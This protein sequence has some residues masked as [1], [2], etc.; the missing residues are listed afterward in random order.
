M[1]DCLSVN[2]HRPSPLSVAGSPECAALGCIGELAKHELG[3]EASIIPLWFLLQVPPW[4]PALTS[5]CDAWWPRSQAKPF[6]PQVAFGLSVYRSTREEART[7][8]LTCSSKLSLPG[9]AFP[10]G[11]QGAE[12]ISHTPLGPRSWLADLQEQS[13][14]QEDEKDFVQPKK[15]KPGH[16]GH[17]GTLGP[18]ETG[19]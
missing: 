5:L 13:G 15:T 9:S 18:K 7:D 3:E 8:I 4:F 10:Q 1:E 2:S 11:W 12:M 16:G 19:S 14:E 17:A 6:F